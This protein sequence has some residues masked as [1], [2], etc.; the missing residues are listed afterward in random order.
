MKVYP[1]IS[2]VIGNTPVVELGSIERAYDLKGR[3]FAKLE[4]MNPAGSAKDRIAL[5]MIEELER[6]GRIDE[7]TKLIEPTSGNTGLGLA[8]ICAAKGYHAVIIMPE[9]M[10]EERKMLA[11]AY[12]AELILTPA[13]QGM[14]GAVA[15]AE[16]MAAADSRC[17]IAGQFDN[18]ANPAAHYKTT[19]PEIWADMDGRVDA[20][21]AG[22]GTG[23]TLCGTGRYLRERKSD[24]YI[25]AAEPFESPLLS[26]GRSGA[27]GI[28]G[29]G[30]NFIP[31]NMDVRL[32][33]E[34]MTVKTQDALDMMKELSKR[35]GIFA[36]ISS[37][38]AVCA[39]VRLA[40]RE[41]FA[42]KNI[43]VILP[44]SGERYLS[45]IDI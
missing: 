3:V 7:N 2:G 34:I 19:G 22:V 16:Q 21:V 11:R 4:F 9:S 18:P 24:L 12:G 35:T 36:G 17:V 32:P 43:V 10:S 33:D 20:L 5:E 31:G 29:I 45:A 6:R 39:A 1:D 41:A 15:R 28:Q 40:K 8:A 27:H 25:C 42:G 38:C 37:G 44:D 14:A 23:G 13:D 30:A 26:E